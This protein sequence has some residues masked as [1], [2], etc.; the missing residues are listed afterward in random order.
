LTSP[1]CPVTTLHLS[2]H[3]H[4]VF[5]GRRRWQ[6][7]RV[8]CSCGRGMAPHSP[9]PRTVC[10][11]SSA[12]LSSLDSHPCIGPPPSRSFSSRHV[13]RTP[14]WRANPIPSFL[15]FPTRTST[16]SAPWRRCSPPC[17][18]LVIPLHATPTSNALHR[19][20]RPPGYKCHLA[21]LSSIPPQIWNRAH[22][23][24]PLH[25]CSGGRTLGS[26]WEGSGWRQSYEIQS[27]LTERGSPVKS[28][29]VTREEGIWFLL[30]KF[31]ST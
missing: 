21:C 28:N 11:L 4:C 5:C 14:P 3:C 23:I 16:R 18:P 15:L 12:R 6:G 25:P 9:T 2:G 17:D 19:H 22:R 8:L 31:K 10:P 24:D 20:F 26:S 29:G 1:L 13:A 27:L 30:E 7:P